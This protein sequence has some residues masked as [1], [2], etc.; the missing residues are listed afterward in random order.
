MFHFFLQIKLRWASAFTCIARQVWQEAGIATV[1]LAEIIQVEDG[2]IRLGA[3]YVVTNREERLPSSIESFLEMIKEF[4][5]HNFY[6]LPVD[7]KI[8]SGADETALRN[9]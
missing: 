9:T 2:E 5:D 8:N 6:E 4:F 3:I 7:Q 1:V